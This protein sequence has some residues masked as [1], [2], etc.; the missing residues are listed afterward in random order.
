MK[1]SWGIFQVLALVLLGG[2]V[3]VWFFFED[4]ERTLPII[5][6]VSL[7]ILLSLEYIRE[8]L[9]PKKPATISRKDEVD[10]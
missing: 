10:T 9:S 5:L 3:Y 4:D 6:L 7:F 8:G 2:I 1:L